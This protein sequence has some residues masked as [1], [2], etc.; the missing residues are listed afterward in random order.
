MIWGYPHFRKR[1][2]LAAKMGKM[3]K[4]VYVI[5]KES[6]LAVQKVTPAATSQP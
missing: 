1:P 4:S 6:P 5:C 3:A 2:Y